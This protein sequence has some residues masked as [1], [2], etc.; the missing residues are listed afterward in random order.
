MHRF[1]KGLN[2]SVP[3][4]ELRRKAN[5]SDPEQ[6]LWK[7]LSKKPLG[8]MQMVVQYVSIFNQKEGR[9]GAAKI[10]GEHGVNN[11]A[12]LGYE[13]AFFDAAGNE[14]S[15]LL[16]CIPY[17]ASAARSPLHALARCELTFEQPPQ[18]FRSGPAPSASRS[19]RTQSR[20]GTS[21]RGCSSELRG[22]RA[23]S[24][25]T[26]NLVSFQRKNLSQGGRVH[27]AKCLWSMVTS[28]SVMWCVR[29]ERVYDATV[30]RV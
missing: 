11:G 23:L 30:L 24:F 7:R 20:R 10:V 9:Q 29:S 5:E 22:D 3:M 26:N 28:A 13:I 16:V 8:E 6:A 14:L 25:F 2:S 12:N 4:K 19:P 18:R 21:P 1:A 15:R 27:G 17:K